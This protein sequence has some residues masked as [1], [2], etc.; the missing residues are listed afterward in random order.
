MEKTQIQHKMMKALAITHKGL[1]DIG[2]LEIN[3]LT[4]AKTTAK[5]TCVIFEP[6]TKEDIALVCYKSQSIK[7]AIYLFDSF[8]LKSIKNLKDSIEKNSEDIKEFIK[9]DKTFAVRCIKSENEDFER[10]DIC[11]ETAEALK[12]KSK[13]D[14]K[15]P[16]I[17]MFIYLHK[18]DC[19]IGID[20]SGEDLGKRD[21]RIYVHHE[22]LKAPIAYSLLRISD[23]KRQNTILDPFCGSG[24]ILIEAAL[25]SKNFS[26]N[27]YSKDKF[28]FSQFL[29]VNLEKFDKETEFKGKIIGYDKELRHI[30]AA[31]KN[32]KIADIEK[33]I[34]FSRVEID[35]LDT[36]ITEKSIDKI[37]TNPPNLTK[38]TNEK[39][40]E[41]IYNELFHQAGFVLKEKGTVTVI[42]RT[43][44][45]IKK[46]A[47]KNK[48]NI[49]KEKDLVIGKDNYKIF[50][51]ER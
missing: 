47:E 41:K 23:Y 11:M 37:I 43:Y 21:Y 26:Q 13:V 8:K 42:T 31:K 27:H 39:E 50:I 19:Y 3:E 34:N 2:S 10:E 18:D 4:G 51:F 12:T 48:F 30:I 28:A 38:R 24:T 14:L 25:S 46:A 36:K 5:E 44:D 49:V 6:K 32:A 16:D 22:A 29:E 7:K 9:E 17:I 1:E 35:W 33:S 40:I 20:F 45:L 15:N